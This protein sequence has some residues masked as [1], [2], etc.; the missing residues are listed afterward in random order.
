MVSEIFATQDKETKKLTEKERKAQI[1]KSLEFSKDKQ[2]LLEKLSGKK[3]LQFLK[4]L[5]ER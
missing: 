2:K 3:E 5:V 4:S 1:K